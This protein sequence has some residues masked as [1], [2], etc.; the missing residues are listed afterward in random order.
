MQWGPTMRRL[1]GLSFLLIMA[2]GCV[3]G[4]ELGA[5]TSPLANMVPDLNYN[6]REGDRAHLFA[7]Q[8]GAPVE[9]VVVLSDLTS[10]DQYERFTH[11]GDAIE[12]SNME[13]QGKLQNVPLGTQILITRI[14]NRQHTGAQ[15]G[16]EVK[17]LDGPQKGRHVWTRLENIARLKRAEPTE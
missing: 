3:P 14:A 17:V 4:G 6:P 7:V 15:V 2:A 13:Q 16:A 5:S 11:D 9:Q 8:N 12:V 10:Y 1:L